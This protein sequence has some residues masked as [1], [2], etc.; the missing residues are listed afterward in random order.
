MATKVTKLFKP[1]AGTVHWLNECIARGKREPFSEVTLLT[2]GLAAELLR[3]N[4][5]NRVLSASRVR[6]IAADILA[7]RWEL[8]LQPIVMSKCGLLNDGQTRCQ[9]VIDANRPIQVNIQFGAERTTR[10]TLDQIGKRTAA[11]YGTMRGRQHAATAAGLARLV[12]AYE[13]S[14]GQN[15]ADT[16][17][18]TN[19]E[20]DIRADADPAITESAAFAH[21]LANLAR[22]FCA[23]SPIGACHYILS[24]EHAPDAEA[25][26]DQVCVGENIRRSDPA[27]AV[28]ERLLTSGKYAGQKME[29]IFRGWNAYRAGRPLKLAKVL[30]TFPALV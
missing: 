20:V 4:P 9:A 16:K 24:R 15:I 13:R 2:P 14:G 3:R 8:N 1:E 11:D 23:P 21:R 6:N 18:V 5:D 26:L 17:Y 19:T 30:G 25:F 29:I 27:F 7:G 28:R 22:P 12:I 10:F